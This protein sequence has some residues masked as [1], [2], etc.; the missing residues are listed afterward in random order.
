MRKQVYTVEVTPP[1]HSV[2]TTIFM[3][4]RLAEKYSNRIPHWR[5][6]VAEFDMDRSTA[7]RWIRG[8]K[9]ARGLP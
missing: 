9:D 2:H 5:E 6:L 4:F 7:Y 1:H 8:M 3:A